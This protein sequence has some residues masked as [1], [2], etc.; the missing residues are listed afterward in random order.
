MLVKKPMAYIYRTS[1]GA[2]E[3]I[4]CL[5]LIKTRAQSG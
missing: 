3:P 5:H 2:P 1:Y 4:H